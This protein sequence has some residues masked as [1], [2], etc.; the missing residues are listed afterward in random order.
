MFFLLYMGMQAFHKHRWG[1]HAYPFLDLLS[2]PVLA[3]AYAS[4]LAVT[5]LTDLAVIKLLA[6]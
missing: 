4:Y 5:L 3:L 1:H 6:I 2:W